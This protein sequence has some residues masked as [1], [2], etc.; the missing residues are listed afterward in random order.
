MSKTDDNDAP[1]DFLDVVFGLDG[2][3]VTI[4]RGARFAPEVRRLADALSID[5]PHTIGLVM[6]L[7]LELGADLEE[8]ATVDDEAIERYAGWAGKPGAFAQ[9]LRDHDWIT[10][11]GDE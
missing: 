1:R 11:P 8:V 3:A 7:A 9:A 5:R 6:M 2:D 4:W 10:D